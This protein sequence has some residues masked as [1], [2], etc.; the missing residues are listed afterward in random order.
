M[1]NLTLQ[2]WGVILGGVGAF[3]SLLWTVIV[4]PLRKRHR[5]IDERQRKTDEKITALKALIESKEAEVRTDFSKAITEAIEKIGEQLNQTAER[6]AGEFKAHV[7]HDEKHHTELHDQ[8]RALIG[9]V[10]EL[11]GLITGMQASRPA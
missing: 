11:K 3:G 2:D 6:W 8:N 10:G 1:E 9:T 5:E 7:V 4:M